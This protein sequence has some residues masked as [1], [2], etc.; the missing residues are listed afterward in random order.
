VPDEICIQ[1][2]IESITSAVETGADPHDRRH[3]DTGARALGNPWND[4]RLS[5]LNRDDPDSFSE[6]AAI[7][8]RF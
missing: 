2:W 3:P 8:F 6:G 4:Y 1:L 5:R 7:R